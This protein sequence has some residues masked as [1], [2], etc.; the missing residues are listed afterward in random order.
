[1][2]A[3]VEQPPVMA[4]SGGMTSLPV[5][6]QDYAGGGIVA[7]ADRGLVEDEAV[8]DPITGVQLSGPRPKPF[9]REVQPGTIYEPSLI[10]DIF[11]GP[12]STPSNASPPPGTTV[13]NPN[14]VEPPD[15][16]PPAPPRREAGSRTGRDA[17]PR[18]P[19]G[20]STSAL[21]R[22][23]PAD[24][25]PDLTQLKPEAFSTR[26]AQ[27]LPAIGKERMDYMRLMGIDPDMY[28]KMIG[29][30]ETKRGELSKRREEAKGLALMEA[31]LG[32]IGARRGEEFQRLGESGRKGLASLTEAGKELRLAEEKLD[33]RINSF[34]MADQQ[35][36]QTGAEKDL[37]KRENELNRVE[38]AQR[39]AV[40]D[41]NTFTTVRAQLGMEGAKIRT[42][43]ELSLYGTDVQAGLER[44][45][46][47]VQRQQAANQAS[48]YSKSLAL[49]EQ[50]IKSMDAATQARVG[51]LQLEA[52]KM[53]EGSDDNRRL[54]Q[55]L[56]QKY[57]DSYMS[58]PDA[59]MQMN[60][61]RRAYIGQYLD[62]NDSLVHAAR[63]EST[64]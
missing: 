45:K 30:E 22:P 27:E 25:L 38:A 7:F 13:T 63:D 17:G 10:S 1:M 51:K 28:N 64:L 29:K 41:R 15:A 54:N 9:R 2:G 59:Q 62:Q 44:E 39:E 6:V 12:I 19:A 53:W 24:Y 37:T 49:T 50:R 16:A 35:F 32:L 14:Y 26:A 31:S 43:G 23:N 34:R 56:K 47:A 58:V 5:E 61:A 48:Y 36:K 33:D 8:Y 52:G 4:A 21:K 18:G 3:P 46:I 40:K 57:G 42:Q 60:Q 20:P 55:M 11:S